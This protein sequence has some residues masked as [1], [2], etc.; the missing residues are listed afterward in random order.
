MYH[1]YQSLYFNILTPTFIKNNVDV[2]YT[3]LSGL[4]FLKKLAATEEVD[5]PIKV[6]VNSW[7]P[8]WRMIEL[9]DEEEREKILV[10]ANDKKKEAEYLYSNRIY[11]VDKKYHKKYDIPDN[12]K[13][14]EVFEIDNTIIY[15]VY[16]KEK[17]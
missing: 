14:I 3:G 16:K 5:F 10:F 2:D 1:P 11:D 15:E 4:S 6:S 8:L 13:K 7:Y 9:L 17:K 12:F